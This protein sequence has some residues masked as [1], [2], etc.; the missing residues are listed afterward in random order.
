MRNHRLKFNKELGT[1]T[2]DD[3]PL[4]IEWRLN[5]DESKAIIDDA[6]W[7]GGDT[8]PLDDVEII[9]LETQPEFE[10]ISKKELQILKSNLKKR[11]A[12][13]E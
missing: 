1:Y 2:F 4:E 11:S 3:C 8:E 5:N 9:E 7:V 6:F 13:G 12:R 10:E